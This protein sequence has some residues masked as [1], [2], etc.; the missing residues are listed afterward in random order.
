MARVVMLGIGTFFAGLY[1]AFR[2][3]IPYFGGM[4][5]GVILRRGYN[6]I[7]IRRDEEPERFAKLLSARL[8]GA[9]LGFGLSVGGACAA[10][11]GV[12][13]FMRY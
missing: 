3:L 4:R 12:S 9:L 7:S 1:F 13:W 5:S 10:V 6:A 11:V 8:R 2:D